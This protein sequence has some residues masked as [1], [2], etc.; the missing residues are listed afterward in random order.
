MQERQAVWLTGQVHQEGVRF[1]P[2]S[3]QHQEQHYDPFSRFNS[4]QQVQVNRCN[5]LSPTWGN[6]H[7]NPLDDDNGGK[8]GQR[9]EKNNFD[10]DVNN[11]NNLPSFRGR[12]VS[13][14]KNNVKVVNERN[15]ECQLNLAGGSRIEV[16]GKQLP[17]AGDDIFWKG[18]EQGSGQ[19]GKQYNAH[20]V[21]CFWWNEIAIIY[22]NQLNYQ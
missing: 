18:T 4:N 7:G 9:F 19:K 8:G 10:C 14:S 2:S 15:E 20:H 1:R 16:A 21:F 5:V 12:V 3:R 6:S 17:E 13:I 11:K 22:Y